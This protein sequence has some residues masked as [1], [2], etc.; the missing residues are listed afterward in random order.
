MTTTIAGTSPDHRPSPASAPALEPRMNGPRRHANGG[1][2][3]GSFADLVGGTATVTLHRR[4]PLGR[5]FGVL[6]TPDG[7][8]VLDGDAPVATVRP[9]SPFVLEPP[10]RPTFA[11]AEEARRAHPYVNRR[12]PLSTC[13]VCGP[14]RPDGLHVTPGPVRY[15]PGILAAPYDPPAHFATDGHALPASV[16]GALDCVSY[17]AAVL[18]ADRLALLGSLTAHRTREI[19]VGEPLIAVG[20]TIGSGRRSHRTASALL[21]EDGRVVAAAHAVWVEVRHQRLVRLAGRWL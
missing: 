5:T 13:V 2:A 8:S 10:V 16:W 11:Q 3:S 9:V 12:H 21:D 7:L 20:W 17:P 4:V 14:R 18:A 15:Q 19:A 1:F 6:E